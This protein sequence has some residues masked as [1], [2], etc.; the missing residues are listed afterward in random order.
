MPSA[1]T[2]ARELVLHA[3]YAYVSA[4]IEPGE[5]F[6]NVADVED[7]PPRSAIKYAHDLYALTRDHLGWADETI[8]SLARNWRLERIATI[9]RNILRLALVELKHMV[10]VPIKVAINEAIE[11]AK[12]Y[13]TPQSPAFVNG[14]L[15]A[16][17]NTTRADR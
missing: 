17:V 3:L 14:I 9:D 12:K 11:L 10:D 6:E 2:R 8:T 4:G 15:D 16:F 7:H 5:N 1:R 13:S